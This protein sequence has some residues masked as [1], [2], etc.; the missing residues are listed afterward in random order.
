MKRKSL[1]SSRASLCLFLLAFISYALVYMTKNCYS[2]AMASIVNEG[3]MTKSQ[4]GL[5]AAIFY[6]VYAPFQIVGGI[7]ADRYSPGKLIVIGVFGAGICNL[8]V[9]FF[10][11]NYIAM[12]II[13]ALNAVMQFGIWPSIFKIVTTQLVEEHRVKGMFYISMSSTFGLLISYLS[14]MFITNWKNNFML[15]ALSMFVTGF[16][17]LFLYRL[18]EQKMVEDE[19]PTEKKKSS[20]EKKEK[21][22]PLM[23]KAGIPLLLI[24]YTV[25]SMLNLGIKALTP[26]ML[27]ESYDSVSPALANGLNAILVLASPV[28]IIFARNRFFQKFSAPT[29]IASF[30]AIALPLLFMIT[31][32]GKI[33]VLVV[34]CALAVLM[35]IL[36]ATSIFFSSISMYFDRFGYVATLSGLL[37][38]MASLGIVLANYVFAKIAE[39]K[40]WEFTTS[41]W[42]ISAVSVLVLTLITIPIWRNFLK[43]AKTEN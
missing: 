12:M 32:I 43:K 33:P 22:L 41:C 5:I 30:L 25:H 28:G 20:V 24:V 15:S 18:F 4:T 26:V 35:V 16:V 31:L 42:L 40:G 2:A 14:A 6:L 38:C 21:F 39:I 3:I 27:M 34:L 23:F 1:I 29:I 36:A 17:F 7:A 11:E 8:L 37:N 9:Y 19:Q 13:W 10:S